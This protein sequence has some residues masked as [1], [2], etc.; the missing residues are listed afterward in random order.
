MAFSWPRSR[1]LDTASS[2]RGW[3]RVI[4][5]WDE[6]DYQAR[7]GYL[8]PWRASN[9]RT[10]GLNGNSQGFSSG[11]AVERSGIWDIL[12]IRGYG[13]AIP[14]PPL[15][16]PVV[17]ADEDY[18]WTRDF[19]TPIARFL[20]DELAPQP[21]SPRP[22][23]DEDLSRSIELRRQQDDEP[24]HAFF[25][26]PTPPPNLGWDEYDWNKAF[27]VSWTAEDAEV[28]DFFVPP[29]PLAWDDFDWNKFF[30]ERRPNSDE[31]LTGLLPIVPAPPPTLG[32][33]DWDWS[34]DYSTAYAKAPEPEPFDF[35]RPIV[36]SLS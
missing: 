18:Q 22:A 1:F 36:P 29:A 8:F 6:P 25:S 31:E 11:D 7:P 3:L 9:S 17:I 5:R 14:E 28:I 20:D 26:V 34:R 12:P 33:D 4:P 16:V 24:W 23:Y 35:T 30:G 15:I 32:W 10:W 21:F 19:T 27:N 13:G 2:G